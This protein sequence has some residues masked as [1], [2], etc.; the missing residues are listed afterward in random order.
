MVEAAAD[1][2]AVLDADGGMLRAVAA[3]QART[4]R[5]P[6]AGRLIA[7]HRQLILQSSLYTHKMVLLHN[8]FCN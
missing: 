7:L 6:V 4:R 1:I 3:G 5:P 2:E 8:D